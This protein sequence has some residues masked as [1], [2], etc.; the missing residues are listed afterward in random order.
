MGLYGRHV[1]FNEGW[2]PYEERA[3][4]L[5][6]ADIGVSTHHDYVEN[7]FSFRT[8][9]LDYVWAG[10][11][12]IVSAGDSASEEIVARHN[13]GCTVAPGDVDGLAQAIAEMLEMPDLRAAYRSRFQEIRQ[14]LTWT[15]AVEPLARFCRDPRPAADRD[16]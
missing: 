3:N 7:L 13:L 9:I 12:M 5:L 16:I 2:V 15:H 14:A 8:R 4:Y 11:P 10:L 1:F 6:E